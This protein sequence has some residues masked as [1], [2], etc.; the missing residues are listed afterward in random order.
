MRN[1]CGAIGLCVFLNI[2]IALRAYKSDNYMESNT[3]KK[4]WTKPIQKRSHEQN[5]YQKEAMNKT[6]TKWSKEIKSDNFCYRKG[7]RTLTNT[8]LGSSAVVDK[9]FFASRASSF[10]GTYFR[11]G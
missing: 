9:M 3:K 7:V 10:P 4:P 8:N 1:N 2:V 6:N 5:Q 11:L